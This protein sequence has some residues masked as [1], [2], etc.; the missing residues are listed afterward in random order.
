[1]RV[2]IVGGAGFIGTALAEA[3]LGR[4]VDVCVL[5]SERRLARNQTQLARM[6]TQAFDFSMDRSAAV[7]LRGGDTL[8]H[9]GSTTTPALS[10]R[11]MAH[12]AQ[13]NIGP[14]VRLFE[15]AA[16]VGISRVIFASSGGT[17]YGIPECLPIE[18]SHPT[19]P[20]SAYGVSKLSIEN[21]L[22]LY[23]GLNG[24]SLRIA[25][26]YG[27]YQLKG[28]AVGVIARY[29]DAVRQGQP[30]EVWG[31]GSVVR[32]YIAIQDLVEAICVAIAV[33]QLES[34]A[35]NIGSGKPTSVNEIIRAI[36]EVA[37]REVSVRHTPART[38]DVPTVVL[39]N[40][41]FSEKTLWMPRTSLR[42]GI[43]ELWDAASGS[44][45]AGLRG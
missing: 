31:D 1:M 34:G 16:A 15:A 43:S 17:V 32:D 33:P 8:V 7:H 22:R 18:E 11:D 13:S 30:V 23:P 5:D 3:L 25:N 6:E 27:P 10:M 42:Q 45:A 38:F 20:L 19:R 41:R 26:P 40:R 44:E 24:I 36:F 21:Y 28:S 4:G 35:Y 2:V 29:V 37:A 14:S 39:S 12:D 9:L